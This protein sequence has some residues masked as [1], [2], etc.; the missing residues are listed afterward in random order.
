MIDALFSRARILLA[1]LLC[2]VLAGALLISVEPA[3][4]LAGSVP[5]AEESIE[6]DETESPT[7]EALQIAEGAPPAPAETSAEEVVAPSV[8]GTV[9]DGDGIAGIAGV[10]VS[11]FRLI[12]EEYEFVQTVATDDAGAYA[13]AALPAGEYDFFFDPA[14]RTDLAWGWYAG[15]AVPSYAIPATVTEGGSVHLEPRRMYEAGAAYGVV[16]NARTG[17]PLPGVTVTLWATDGADETGSAFFQPI[18]Q[19]TTNEY[20]FVFVQ[21][22]AGDYLVEYAPPSVS[23][24]GEW[25]DD[26]TTFDDSTML[27]LAPGEEREV[28]ADL[29]VHLA[30]ATPSISGT[31]AVGALMTAKPNSWT[32]GATLTYQW[33]A[34]GIAIAGATS[35]SFTVATAQDGKRISV[36]VTGTK[37]GYTTVTKTSG[38][39]AAVMRFATPKIAGPIAAGHTVRVDRGT[40]TSGAAFT[41]QWYAD[42]RAI[43]GATS[44]SYKIPSTLKGKRISVK[45]TGKKSGHTTVSRTSAVSGKVGTAITPS[46][47]GTRAVGATLTAKRGTWTSGTTYSYQWYANGNAISGATGSTYR[48]SSGTEGKRITVKVTGRASGYATVSLTSSAT[49]QILRAGTPT[50]GGTTQVT[51]TVTASRGTWTTGTSFSY[52]WYVNGSAISGATGSTLKLTTS[53]V[54][55]RITVKVTGRLSGYA[56]ISKTSAASATVGYPS[57]TAPIST[58]N[59]PSWA[60]IKGNADSMI[61]HMLGGRYYSAT[62][63]EECFRTETAAVSAGYRKS[64]L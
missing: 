19:A 42:G 17:N 37:L 54:G 22:P 59:C 30:A 3:H 26:T 16:T 41:Y 20:G 49:S 61:Y 39:T 33:L 10:Q 13:F 28:S 44:S 6:L 56:T 5:A 50:I 24:R 11:A 2:S 32:T 31:A 55:K 14:E 52:Q 8:S 4:A 40:W 25:W 1:I 9:T 21:L 15:F 58:W 12:G 29:L 62:Q 53:H 57:R 35:S 18:L 46:I 51:K 34:D 7:V 63:P 38:Q 23:F 64:K 60:P 36:A 27:T 43:S 47:S 48:L 45:V